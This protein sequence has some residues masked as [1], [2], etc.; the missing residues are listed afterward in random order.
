MTKKWTTTKLIILRLTKQGG[1]L[2]SVATLG[3]HTSRLSW[4]RAERSKRGTYL[5]ATHRS[6]LG[7]G[8]TKATHRKPATL[9]CWCL[10]LPVSN[11]SVASQKCIYPD[12]PDTSKPWQLSQVTD[13]FTS[14]CNSATWS[15]RQDTSAL[16]S[17]FTQRKLHH[18]RPDNSAIKTWK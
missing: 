17:T 8:M 14:C 12:H 3:I 9:L 18:R 5:P 15:Q 1:P 11:V 6:L 16:Y 7:K 13:Q 10:W 2:Q 4:D